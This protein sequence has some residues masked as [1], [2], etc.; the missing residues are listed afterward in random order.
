MGC[1]S[2]LSPSLSLHECLHVVIAA[3]RR[4]P[5]HGGAAFKVPR[6]T[7]YTHWPPG[8]LAVLLIIQ[9]FIVDCQVWK[10]TD[11]LDAVLHKSPCDIIQNTTALSSNSVQGCTDAK[12]GNTEETSCSRR[13]TTEFA[14]Q[15]DESTL[16]GNGSFLLAYVRFLKDER[17]AQGCSL[18]ANQNQTLKGS[19]TFVFLTSKPRYGKVHPNDR[20]L[21]SMCS[22]LQKKQCPVPLLV[23]ISFTANIWLPQKKTSVILH[24][25]HYTS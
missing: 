20:S 2:G 17:L 19:S 3:P 7:C 14:L 10:A 15:L 9:H 23:T 22:L 4:L 18:Q 8:L 5:Q 11:I 13:R 24:T 1:G 16:P 25:S 12:A 6:G 21:R